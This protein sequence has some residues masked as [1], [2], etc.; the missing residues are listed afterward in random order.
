ME[1]IN[2]N[3]NVISH[4]VIPIVGDGA[5]LF[6]SLCYVIYNTEEKAQK[7]R[8]TIVNYVFDH[9][10]EF[11]YMTYDKEG[12]NHQNAAD[13]FTDMSRLNVY[14]GFCELAAA[15]KIFPF[16]FEVYYNCK[17]YAK[18]GSEENPVRRLRFTGDL[19]N[20]HF[21]VYL[22]FEQINSSM[23]SNDDDLQPS[24]TKNT[25]RK[26]RSRYTSATRK[27]QLKTACK[28]Y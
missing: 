15:G 17:V 21:D 24:K 27:K 18:F 10:D 25:T 11:Y 7:I 16:L 8:A 23:I 19:L 2:V 12:N 1:N 26:R 4:Q 22:P 14:G 9:W 13:Y 3:G 6:R 5:C 20:G 28:K